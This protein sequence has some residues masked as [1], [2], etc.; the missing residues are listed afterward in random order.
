MELFRSACFVDLMVVWEDEVGVL[1]AGR[2]QESL[3]LVSAPSAETTAAVETTE[4][5]VE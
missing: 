2:K 4:S 5:V 3:R 1:I